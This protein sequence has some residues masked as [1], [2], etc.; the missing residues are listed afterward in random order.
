MAVTAVAGPGKVP[1][2]VGASIKYTVGRVEIF[3]AAGYAAAE[4]QQQL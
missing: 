2:V 3:V 1:S 4:Q